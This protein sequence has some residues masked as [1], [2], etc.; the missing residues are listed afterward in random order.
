MC[1][2]VDNGMKITTEYTD[3]LNEE[4]EPS[5]DSKWIVTAQSP[6]Q[7]DLLKAHKKSIPIFVEGPQYTW[8]RS[9][10]VEY[11]V[12]RTDPLPDTLEKI[13]IIKSANEDDVTNL[14]NAFDDPFKK[15]TSLV[16]IP[17]LTVHELVEGTI[18]AMCVTESSS[19]SSLYNWTKLLEKKIECLKDFVVVYKVRF[20]SNLI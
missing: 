20:L 19:K 9:K 15:S 10:M 6:T 1:L 17:Q 2:S 16:K 4:R 18:Y 3:I 12:M 7:I 14:P 11:F 13:K 5:D 8:L